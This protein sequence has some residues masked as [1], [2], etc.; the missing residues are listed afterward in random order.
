MP[1]VEE[2][3][4][5]SALEPLYEDLTDEE[6]QR[7]VKGSDRLFVS[8]WHPSFDF[9]STL[10]D[11]D[12][13]QVNS[14]TA[15]ARFTCCIRDNYLLVCVLVGAESGDEADRGNARNSSYG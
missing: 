4:L 14:L 13:I 8:K 2:Q 12:G 3:R 5:L 6:H 10:Y 11:P 15:T 1:F 9:L 7:A